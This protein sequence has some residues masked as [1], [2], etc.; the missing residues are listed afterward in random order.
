[1]GLDLLLSPEKCESKW[2][3]ESE[4]DHAPGLH[5]L[6]VANL[7]LV[8]AWHQA[9]CYKELDPSHPCHADVEENSKENGEGNELEDGCKGGGDV[10]E[11]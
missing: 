2:L 10:E 7:G 5:I 1:M 11:F 6:H 8:L 4:E 9:K 3:E